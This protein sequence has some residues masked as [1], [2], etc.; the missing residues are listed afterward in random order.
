V[1]I[2]TKEIDSGRIASEPELKRRFW[3]LAKQL[4]PD[5]Q[6]V[7]SNHER[8]IRLKDDFDAAL[9]LLKTAAPPSTAEPA[10]LRATRQ[11]GAPD[12]ALCLR[13]FIDLMAS[14]FPVDRS[15]RGRKIYLAR[16]E[17]LNTE[18]GRFGAAYGNLFLAFEEEM[19][20]LKG[21][22]TVAN[23][24]FNLMKL[25]LYRSADYFSTGSRNSRHYLAGGFD[26]IQGI[27]SARNMPHAKKFIAWLAGEI[28]RPSPSPARR[29]EH[30]FH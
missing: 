10:A 6:S 17:R 23:H 13:L 15:I 30:P 29:A 19:Y 18:L 22:T 28:A 21:K 24:E 1:N 27:L 25:Y 16:V 8:F 4:H 2:F 3:K 12:R 9:A 20:A 26:Q 7:Q 14:N 5:A 11:G